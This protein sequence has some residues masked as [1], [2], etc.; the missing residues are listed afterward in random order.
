MIDEQNKKSFL[1]AAVVILILGLAIV[2]F[3]LI[4]LINNSAGN[5]SDVQ[6]AG[7]PAASNVQFVV[8]AKTTW[9]EGAS[10]TAQNLSAPITTLNINC[11]ASPT[12]QITGATIQLVG[13]NGTQTFQS[14]SA[15]NVSIRANGS[16][17]ASCILNS[18]VCNTDTF[19]LG[20]VQKT[21]YRCTSSSG[22]ANACESF[23]TSTSTCPS[24]S[25]ESATG[26]AQASGGSCP[27]AL[28]CYRCSTSTSDGN[29]CESFQQVGSACPVGTASTATGCAT[30]AGGTCP[31]GGSGLTC[32]RCTSIA[33]DGNACESFTTTTAT[34]PSGSST[35]ST[36]CATSAGGSCPVVAGLPNT[37]IGDNWS[38]YLMIGL[39]ILLIVAGVKLTKKEYSK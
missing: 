9:F 30:A 14:P 35:N 31:A 29:T 10:I 36:G 19:A 20:G 24:G 13:P 12:S 34:C 6:V 39:A 21:C 32:F 26:C 22:D 8:G 23:T 18:Q 4:N 27:I 33:S 2:L 7:C 37:A 38:D 3:A 15:D 16:Y 25:S 5:N 1:I 11:F 17:T 28:T